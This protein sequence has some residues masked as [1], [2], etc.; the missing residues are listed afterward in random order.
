MKRIRWEGE[1]REGGKQ[2]GNPG[3]APKAGMLPLSRKSNIQKLPSS[4]R[5]K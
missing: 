5:Q 3:V 1:E 2:V 4:M